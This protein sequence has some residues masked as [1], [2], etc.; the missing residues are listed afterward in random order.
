MKRKIIIISLLAMIVSLLLATVSNAAIEI[1]DGTTV[2]KSVSVSD[3]FQYCYDMRHPTSSLGNNNLDPHLS[4][5]TDWGAVVYLSASGYGTVRTANGTNTTI[6]NRSYTTTTGNASGVLNL[7]VNFTQMSGIVDVATETND[8]TNLYKN[9]NSKYVGILSSTNDVESTRGQA[10]AEIFGW[11]KN[12]IIKY[13]DILN[14]VSIRKSIL[15]T[16]WTSS[17]NFMSGVANDMTTYRPAMW[18]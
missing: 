9:R 4:L 18:N 5:D 6:N 2:H 16:S 15:G 7:G 1:K 8:I 3:S 14:P 12:I 11:Q 17:I 10:Y 13:P